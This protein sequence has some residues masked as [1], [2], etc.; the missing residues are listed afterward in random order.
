[1]DVARPKL[2][3]A[4]FEDRSGQAIDPAYMT[5][6]TEARFRLGGVF[7]IVGETGGPHFIGKGKILRLAETGKGGA[8]VSVYTLTLDMVDPASQRT[9]QSCEATVEGEL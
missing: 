2:Y 3:I 6:E 1:M 8:R 7:D 5:S 9:V 4:S